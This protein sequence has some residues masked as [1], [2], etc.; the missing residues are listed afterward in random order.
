MPN[1]TG[2]NRESNRYILIGYNKLRCFRHIF[3]KDNILSL[4]PIII[5]KSVGQLKLLSSRKPAISPAGLPRWRFGL[6]GSFAFRSNQGGAGCSALK[7]GKCGRG[8]GSVARAPCMLV[9]S[10]PS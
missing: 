6:P 5:E 3:L 9:P 10:V 8:G 7:V 2:A 4:I 1:W